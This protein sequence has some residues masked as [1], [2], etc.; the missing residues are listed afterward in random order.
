MQRWLL[1]ANKFYS[2]VQWRPWLLILDRSNDWQWTYF[3]R[4][5]FN[6]IHSQSALVDKAR[7][8]ALR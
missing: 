7:Q 1:I 3:I 8:C 5:Q 6:S 2:L 4:W